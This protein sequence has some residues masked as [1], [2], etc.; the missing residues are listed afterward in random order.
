[1]MSFPAR[2]IGLILAVAAAAGQAGCYSWAQIPQ[3]K[4][5]IDAPSRAKVDEVYTFKVDVTTA[6]GAVVEQI[7]YG[8]L[9]DWPEAKGMLHTGISSQPQ[10]MKV[11]GGAGK[12][13]LRIYAND[14]TGRRTQID[15]F[16]FQV[17]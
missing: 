8:W 12:A 4:L 15:K 2:P 10:Q 7:R 9:I 11:K 16:E 17:E 5:R 1:M 13:L 14:A 3:H 6:E